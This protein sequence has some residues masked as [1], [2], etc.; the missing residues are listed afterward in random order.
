MNAW[1]QVFVRT[2]LEQVYSSDDAGAIIS[3]AKQ[4]G[5]SVLDV[6][7]CT[8]ANTTTTED[9]FVTPKVQ[10]KSLSDAGKERVLRSQDNK[11]TAQPDVQN[12]IF[13]IEQSS[14]AH[15]FTATADLTVSAAA[16][17]LFVTDKP[18]RQALKSNL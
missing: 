1:Q 2:A 12:A 13:V 8:V 14:A 16:S 4:H 11:P 17:T 7:A 9:L 15:S 10:R 18:K 3:F 5:L 6:V